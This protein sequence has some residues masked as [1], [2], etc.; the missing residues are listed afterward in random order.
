VTEVVK[1]VRQ[2]ST[3]IEVDAPSGRLAVWIYLLSDEYSPEVSTEDAIIGFCSPEEKPSR[4]I[5]RM[6]QRTGTGK[7]PMKVL[8]VV[9]KHNTCFVP[10]DINLFDYATT[11]KVI[12]AVEAH[13]VEDRKV[14]VM[15]TGFLILPN[16]PTHRLTLPCEQWAQFST[17]LNPIQ[18]HNCDGYFDVSYKLSPSSTTET[19][20]RAYFTLS[21]PHAKEHPAAFMAVFRDYAETNYMAGAKVGM[22]HYRTTA[23]IAPN[24]PTAPTTEGNSNA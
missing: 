8:C 11:A 9:R 15:V 5:I 16:P 10:G 12:A 18:D 1:F 20:V 2:P 3:G 22:L 24:K 19:K 7:V 21:G 14:P 17:P 23:G 6:E 4:A 13:V